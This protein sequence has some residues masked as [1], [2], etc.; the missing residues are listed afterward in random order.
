VEKKILSFCPFLSSVG[1]DD[2]GH[3]GWFSVVRLATVSS[4]A[5]MFHF[6]AAAAAVAEGDESDVVCRCRKLLLPY[7]IHRWRASASSRCR[8][9][10]VVRTD[11]GF[12]EKILDCS[13]N[14]S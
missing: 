14:L 9:C 4:P 11:V 13:E 1:G 2:L 5:P 12:T 3:S 6:T 8:G 10:S 7:L